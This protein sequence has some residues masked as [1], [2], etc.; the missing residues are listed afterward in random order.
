MPGKGR[1]KVHSINTR[2][3]EYKRKGIKWDREKLHKRS[4]F[5]R[6]HINMNIYTFRI[7]GILNMCAQLLQSCSTVCN[8]VDSR[9]S[10]FSVSGIL[11]QEYWSGL[12]LLS[13]KD[14]SNP[15]IELA[16]PATPALA[17]RFFYHWSLL[18]GP[19]MTDAIGIICV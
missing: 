5:Q 6:I 8:P 11:Q 19:N 13:P 17:G 2:K 9:P 18:E 3:Y 14:L 12:P 4:N 10:G 16:S 15:G 7:K 1:K